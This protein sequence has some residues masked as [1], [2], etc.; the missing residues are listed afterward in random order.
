[1][2]RLAC[3]PAFLHCWLYMAGALP[4]ARACCCATP[5]TVHFRTYAAYVTGA[6]LSKGRGVLLLCGMHTAGAVSGVRAALLC[7]VAHA[8][9][10]DARERAAVGGDSSVC[11]ATTLHKLRCSLRTQG[12]REHCC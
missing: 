8:A 11:C 7:C 1:M 12:H 2:V 5:G 6:L 4:I 10:L 3:C 9:L